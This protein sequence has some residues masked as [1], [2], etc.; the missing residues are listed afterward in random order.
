[1]FTHGPKYCHLNAHSNCA[2]Q[3]THRKIKLR[4]HGPKYHHWNDDS[5]SEI[6]LIFQI[7]HFFFHVKPV[8]VCQEIKFI[9]TVEPR[10]KEVGYSKNRLITR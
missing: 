4:T 10:Y 5:N 2:I 3:I 9:S 7:M 8:S 6:L 1:M